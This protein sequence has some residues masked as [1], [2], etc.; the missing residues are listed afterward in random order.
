MIRRAWILA[1]VMLASSGSAQLPAWDTRPL[2]AF[3]PRLLTTGSPVEQTMHALLLS[4]RAGSAGMIRPYAR[5]D[6]FAMIVDAALTPARDSGVRWVPVFTSA[7]INTGRSQQDRDGPVWQGRGATIA[8]TAGALVDFRFLSV[9]VRP[10][11]VGAQNG[12]FTPSA[13]NPGPLPPGSFHDPYFGSEIDLP[14]RFGD[15][16][17]VRW[18]PGESWVELVLPVISM[19]FTTATQQ[20]GPAEI[21]PLLMGSQAGGYPRVFARTSAVK[22]RLGTFEALWS[23][24]RLE[25]SGF[26][27]LLAPGARSRIFP[28]FVASWSPFDGLELGAG[29]VFHLRWDRSSVTGSTALLPFRGLLKQSNPTG[30]TSAR[31]Q[32]QAA[33]V[34]AR[35]APPGG[36]VEIFGEFYRED[37]SVNMTDLLAEPDHASAYTLGLRRGWHVARAVRRLSFEVANGRI[38]HIKRVRVQ[39]PNYVHT[40]VREG[41]TSRGQPLGSSA[42]LG[43]GGLAIGFDQISDARSWMIQ[44]GMRRS[45]QNQEGGVWNGQLGGRYSLRGA[46]SL[47]AARTCST[48][49]MEVERGYGLERDTN[50]AFRYAIAFR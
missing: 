15:D 49:E 3:D 22:S 11:I 35:V 16:A 46:R 26:D 37:H 4:G 41:H 33:S 39:A 24:G 13:P 45:V 6:R 48:L 30:E 25:S 10:V 44:G 17:F 47:C 40:I 8:L 19:G 29:R 5:R 1:S 36:G 23:V 50:L 34:F 20:W 21:F 12:Q 31:D 9:A 27:T 43:G 7:W 38:S 18:D 32:N 14:Y 42:V 2:G 28:A